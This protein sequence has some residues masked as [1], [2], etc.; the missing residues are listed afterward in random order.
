MIWEYRN[1]KK[2]FKNEVRILPRVIF[3]S[4]ETEGE[5]NRRGDM[6]SLPRKYPKFKEA[7]KPKYKKDKKEEAKRKRQEKAEVIDIAMA[8]QPEPGKNIKNKTFKEH[9]SMIIQNNF[10]NNIERKKNPN[11][12]Q[13]RE[14]TRQR[15]RKRF[16]ITRL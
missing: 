1:F 5:L 12:T 10:P 15:A 13:I 7:D 11:A 4:D 16:V 8:S 9:K 2:A 3:K 6:P 14:T